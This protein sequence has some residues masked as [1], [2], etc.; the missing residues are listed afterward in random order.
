M[1]PGTCRNI[2]GSNPFGQCVN[3]VHLLNLP[4]RRFIRRRHREG[5]STGHPVNP[6]KQMEQ[7]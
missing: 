5:G 6:S 2:R 4:V 3:R 1:G 7:C